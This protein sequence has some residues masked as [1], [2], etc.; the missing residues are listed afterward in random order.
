M[1]IRATFAPLATPFAMLL[2]TLAVGL[3]MQP[4]HAAPDCANA[5][6]QRAIDACAGNADQRA[7]AELNRQY[8]ALQH[9]L[10]D[11]RDGAKKLTDAQR[12]WIA[13]RDAE[14]AFQTARV[15]G[16]S[17]EPAA[18]ATCL[19]Q[20]TR[21]R[22]AALRHYLSCGEGDLNCPAPAR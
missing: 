12:A 4:A 15:A 10:N 18:R 6:N 3:A 5:Q 17:A 16:G 19:E 20:M 11:D 1:T 22:T 7:D 13:F 2:T 14:C 21:A 9:R 8:R